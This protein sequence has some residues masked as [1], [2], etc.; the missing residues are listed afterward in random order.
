MLSRSASE[1]VACSAGQAVTGTAEAAFVTH[2]KEGII[3]WNRAATCLLGY[4]KKDVLHKPCYNILHG[5]DIHGNAYCGSHC[6]VR[7]MAQRGEPISRFVSVYRSCGGESVP[8]LVSIV[9]FFREGSREPA[10]LHLLCPL[11][12]ATLLQDSFLTKKRTRDI[13]GLA[14][15]VTPRQLQVLR[16]LAEGRSSRDIAKRLSISEVTVRNHVNHLLRKLKVHSRLEAVALAY[17]AGVL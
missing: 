15:S 9:V 6:P 11:E 8:S 4:S 2:S 10:L 14:G 13:V 17:Q 3:A 12:D 1:K 16:L 7:A 5:M